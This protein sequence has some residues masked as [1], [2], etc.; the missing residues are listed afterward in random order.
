MRVITFNTM[1]LYFLFVD[2]EVEGEEFQLTHELH[3]MKCSAAQESKRGNDLDCSQ[4]VL[5]LL[6]WQPN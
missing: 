2:F 4:N 6:P 1:P 3:V 5:K